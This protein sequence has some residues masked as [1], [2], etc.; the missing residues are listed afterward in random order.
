MATGIT[1]LPDTIPDKQNG[2]DDIK[3]SGNQVSD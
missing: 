2:E 1:G 3:D